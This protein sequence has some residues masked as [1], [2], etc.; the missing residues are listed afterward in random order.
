MKKK[1]WRSKNCPVEPTIRRKFFPWNWSHEE[2]TPNFLIVKTTKSSLRILFETTATK[3]SIFLKLPTYCNCATTY[4]SNFLINQKIF[5]WQID[6]LKRKSFFFLHFL[7]KT[8][9]KCLMMSTVWTDQRW[10]GEWW[11]KDRHLSTVLSRYVESLQPRP[12]KN[13]SGGTNPINQSSQSDYKGW[14]W[15]SEMDWLIDLHISGKIV[16]RV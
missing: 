13:R 2:K 14:K 1:C 8:W 10:V 12:R 7:P 5:L 15:K 16:L 3:D 11:Q 4:K 9:L 6:F